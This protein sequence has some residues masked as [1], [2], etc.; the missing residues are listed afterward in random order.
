MVAQGARGRWFYC[1]FPSEKEYI[2]RGE[3][4]ESSC[5]NENDVVWRGKP[6]PFSEMV[7]FL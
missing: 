1:F 3:F 4:G 6:F 7:L 2:W 5:G